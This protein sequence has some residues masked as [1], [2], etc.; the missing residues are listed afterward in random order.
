MKRCLNFFQRARKRHTFF[1][2]GFNQGLSY[3]WREANHFF[4]GIRLNQK[5]G[6]GWASG[7]IATLLERLDFNS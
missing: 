6:Q 4:D 5:T 7:E 3:P 1:P 2:H